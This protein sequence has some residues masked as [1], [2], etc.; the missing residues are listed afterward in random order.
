MRLTLIVL[1][2]AVASYGGWQEP[3]NLGAT[4]NSTSD[5]WY[6]VIPEDGSYMIFVSDRPGGY[7]GGDM[8]ISLNE[9]GEWQTPENLGSNVNT[10]FGESAPFLAEDDTAL[11]FASLAPGGYGQMDIWRCSLTDGVPGP[12]TNLGPQINTGSLECCPVLATDGNTLYI[13]S[14]RAGGTGGMDIWASE[15][16]GD[17]W[18]DPYNIGSIVNTP[19][20]DCPRWISDDGD[21]LVISSTCAGGYGL[22][23]LWYAVRTGDDWNEPVNFGA[24]INTSAHEWGP[25]FYCNHGDVGGVIYFG[26]GRGGGQGGWDLWKSV[27]DDYVEVEPASHGH[28]KALYR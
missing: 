17:T 10:V 9:G 7:G 28:L 23:D 1:L 18:G 19:Q 5:D 13:C 8:W 6:P 22:A 11:Y 24:G 20:T 26:S 25:G 2:I 16:S 14:D 15:K 3:E 4:V 12:K 21:T 27:D